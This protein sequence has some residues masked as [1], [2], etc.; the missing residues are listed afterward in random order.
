M[1]YYLYLAIFSFPCNV[2][3]LSIYLSVSLSISLSL[4]RNAEMSVINTKRETYFSVRGSRI[5]CKSLNNP[6]EGLN[7]ISSPKEE[8]AVTI[9]VANGVVIRGQDVY[10]LPIKAENVEPGFY[11]V[12]L[13]G[14]LQN[15]GLELQQDEILLVP[16]TTRSEVSSTHLQVF[17]N[18]PVQAMIQFPSTVSLGRYH[19]RRKKRRKPSRLLV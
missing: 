5:D 4:Q 14:E 9:K 11:T 8:I 15:K 10:F 16:D 19:L 18:K 3:S 7:N 6:V 12:K 2:V 13:S 1:V 17:F